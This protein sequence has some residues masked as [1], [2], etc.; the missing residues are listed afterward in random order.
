VQAP[1]P[2]LWGWRFS[3]PIE[4]GEGEAIFTASFIRMVFHHNK[5]VRK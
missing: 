4:V 2:L 3:T 1:P 5:C